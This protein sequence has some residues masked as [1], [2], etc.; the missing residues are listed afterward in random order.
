M[1]VIK[2][3]YPFDQTLIPDRPSVLAMG[4]FDGVHR[5]HQA[6]LQRAAAQAQV[7]QVPLAVLTYDKFPGLVYESFPGW[8]Q[9]LT[10]LDQKLAQL[11]RLGVEIAYVVSFTSRLSQLSPQQFVDECL[12]AL[13]PVEVVAGFDHTYGDKAVAT[14][15]NLP[16]YAAGRFVVN[17]VEQLSA[18]KQKVSSTAI[19]QALDQGD[20]AMVND[21][22]G[23]PY[24]TPGTIVHGFARGR[25]IGFPTAN[26]Q[27]AVDQR[28]PAIGVY[29][30]RLKVGETWYPGM[31]SVGHNV[32]FGDDNQKTIE[33]NL[34]DFHDQI[35]GENVVVEWIAHLRGEVKF[36]GVDELI[37]QLQQD[38]QTAREILK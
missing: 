12:M 5:G 35:Y 11:E 24:T 17:V 27:W 1:E 26:V 20:L 37:T 36:D 19:R 10:P 28:I 13:N 29:A 2:L 34:F 15:A 14:M 16:Q 31:A 3:R 33:V 18:T 25:T 9:Y 7:H 21:Y 32:T 38:E 8:F 6:V 22:L 4:F 23:R 30:V